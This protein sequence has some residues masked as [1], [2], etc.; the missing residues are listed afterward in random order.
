MKMNSTTGL[1][2]VMVM[3]MVVGLAGQKA[4]V[5]RLLIEQG[6]R[7]ATTIPND[8][9]PTST[10]PTLTPGVLDTW[11]TTPPAFWTAGF[12][13]GHLWQLFD[14]TK[15]SFFQQQALA[16][17][18]GL[19]GQQY[20]A[21]T[22]DTSF[23]VFQSFGR[24][25]KLGNLSSPVKEEYLDIILQGAETVSTLFDDVIGSL[26]SWQPGYNCHY[27]PDVYTNFTVTIDNMA[28]LDLLFFASEHGGGDK[29]KNMA[30]KHAETAMK[31]M[32][33]EDGSTWQITTYD[34][35]T[36]AVENKCTAFG[37]SDNST[38]SRGQ[39]WCMYG[40]IT[41]YQY[42]NR[43]D[44]LETAKQCSSYFLQ[45]LGCGVKVPLWDFDYDGDN[46]FNHRDSSAAMIGLSALLQIS[47]ALSS[48]PEAE[49]LYLSAK[50][51]E[52]AYDI[53]R[54]V[55]GGVDATRDGVDVAGEGYNQFV[56]KY[57]QTEGVLLHAMGNYP[58]G[59]DVNTSIV[60]ADFYLLESIREMH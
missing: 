14:L 27:D 40:F 10:T 43:A 7:T 51:K 57:D 53:F 3:V 55:A 17:N 42:T 59:S 48:S 37:F 19:K 56:G 24:G 6:K 52:A 36:G 26:R 47:K 13:P 29:Y 25:Y 41:A 22:T 38:W 30:I 11:Q 44:F 1:M 46:D 8:Q 54:D 50:Y 12:F 9:Y 15:N 60:Y 16:W 4:E 31:N 39:A 2:M 5:V 28:Q 49:D 23:K 34:A 32:V 35:Q 33:R 18:E 20:D 45:H 58:G 21:S